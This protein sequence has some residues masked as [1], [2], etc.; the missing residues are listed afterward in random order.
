MTAPH[1][2][3]FLRVMEV[4]RPAFDPR[5]FVHLLV[6]LIGW[7]RTP[8]RHAITEALLVTGVAGVRDHTAFH[9]V[10]SRARWDPD[11]LGRRLLHAL[12]PRLR[13]ALRFV[14]DDT[15]APHKGPQIFGLGCHLDAVRSTRRTKV[16]AFGHQWVVLSIVVTLPWAS[17][18]WA[19]P[20]AF[21]L[22][23]TT[24]ECARRGVPHRSKT[25]LARELVEQLATW[26]PDRAFDVV[27]D[28]AYTNKTVMRGLPARITW[29]GA[30]RPDAA[31]FALPTGRRRKGTR[32]ATPAALAA[33]ASIPWSHT[34]VV[35]YGRAR[36][37]P[38]KAC[39]ACWHHALGPRPLL[40]VVVKC[41]TGD[42]P[43]RV[44]VCTDPDRSVPALLRGY[45][46]RWPQEV[47]FRDSK[48]LLG[49]ADSSA[50]T[51][52]AVLRT[53]PMAGLLYTLL[54]LWFHECRLGDATDVVPQRPWDRTKQHVSFADVLRAAQRML[55]RIDLPSKLPVLEDFARGRPT[56]R[57]PR[58]LTFSFA[59]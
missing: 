4:I 37:I 16:F 14:V 46:E 59:A 28:Q 51:A 2:A 8:G 12:V 38:Y 11:A 22:Y 9:R 39:V 36:T 50:R 15:L 32:V 44:F 42:R 53:A 31:L 29:S 56:P 25:E 45:A 1:F 27:A 30:L 19:L 58:Q 43:L 47:T 7:I 20:L 55:A 57:I 3:A 24:A 6:V 18:A 5:V 34:R 13:Q 23:R 40:V 10:F 49:F 17:R 21:R 41:A 33:D 54:T 35:L 48:Q 52:Q 26:L